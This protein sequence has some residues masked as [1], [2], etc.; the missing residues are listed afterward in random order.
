MVLQPT[1]HWP[2]SQ[3]RTA[4]RQTDRD[5]M[6]EWQTGIVNSA[7]TLPYQKFGRYPYQGLEQLVANT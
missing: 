1:L 3:E 5:R 7:A 4:D 6:N 2:V